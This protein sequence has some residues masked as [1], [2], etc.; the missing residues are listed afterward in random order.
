MVSFR[1]QA[2]RT[3]QSQR[4]TMT[5]VVKSTRLIALLLGCLL[6]G[7]SVLPFAVFAAGETRAPSEGAY[8]AADILGVRNNVD[9]ILALQ[10]AGGAPSE[11]LLWNK[12]IVLKQLLL[13]YLEVRQTSD[14]LDESIDETYDAIDKQV[15][16]VNRRVELANT[17][18][19]TTFG[20]LFNIAAA[21]RL[22]GAFSSSNVLMFTSASLTAGLGAVAVGLSYT[23][24]SVDR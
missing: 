3:A 17:V 21:D 8:E 12:A 5:Q 15:R 4:I 22:R 2:S 6:V 16:T 14:L 13:G 1:L 11:E 7:Q 10:T 20:V 9:R 23:G 18:N 19:F 24:A